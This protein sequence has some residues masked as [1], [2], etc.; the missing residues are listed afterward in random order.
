[1]SVGKRDERIPIDPEGVRALLLDLA[2]AKIV[3]QLR[4]LNAVMKQG[5]GQ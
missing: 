3:F 5:R 4:A 1:V 2:K